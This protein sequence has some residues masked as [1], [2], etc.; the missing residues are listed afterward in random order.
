MKSDR[1]LLEENNQMLRAII[2]YI[3]TKEWD[4]INSGVYGDDFMKNIVANLVSSQVLG[5]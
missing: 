4:K 2:N 5:D 3:V 1:E